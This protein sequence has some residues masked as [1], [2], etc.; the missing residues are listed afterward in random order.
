MHSGDPL[1]V[2]GGPD[3]SE[4][5]ISTGNGSYFRI[6]WFSG[7]TIFRSAATFWIN[8]ARDCEPNVEYKSTYD[9]R[10]LSAWRIIKDIAPGDELLV[11]YSHA[12][13]EVRAGRSSRLAGRASTWA[14]T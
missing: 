8:E 5:Y 12:A 9:G 6:H 10:M 3:F 7:D 11:V 13:N 4:A 14:C 2:V 1:E